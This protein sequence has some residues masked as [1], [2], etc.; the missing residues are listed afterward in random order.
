LGELGLLCDP[1][2]DVVALS[3]EGLNAGAAAPGVP[4]LDVVEVRPA[5]V[6]AEAHE[7]GRGEAPRRVGVE[8][9]DG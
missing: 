8:L 9:G 5:G 7:E 3:V 2:V 1:A 4:G 6:T